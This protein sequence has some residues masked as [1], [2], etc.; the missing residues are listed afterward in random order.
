MSQPQNLRADEL[1]HPTPLSPLAAAPPT[2]ESD[3]VVGLVSIATPRLRAVDGRPE[4][5]GAAP[6]TAPTAAA[7]AGPGA[8]S[9]PARGAAAGVGAGGEPGVER[10]VPATVRYAESMA[11]DALALRLQ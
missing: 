4:A 9:G 3:D 6:R 2:A 8:M 5:T 11:E 10:R 7:G 1:Q